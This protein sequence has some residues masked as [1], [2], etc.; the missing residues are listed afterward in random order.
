[1]DEEIEEVKEY[2]ARKKEGNTKKSE[3]SLPEEP[4]EDVDASE[5]IV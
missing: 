2:L 1:M 5:D 4:I 3:G